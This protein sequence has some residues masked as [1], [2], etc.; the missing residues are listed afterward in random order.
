MNQLE[1]EQ[2][3]N[4]KKVLLTGAITGIGLVAISDNNFIEGIGYG[5]LAMD[6]IYAAS[7]GLYNAASKWCSETLEK[8]NITFF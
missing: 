8:Y 4:F 7:H 6:G 2:E 1:L 3:K 5:I